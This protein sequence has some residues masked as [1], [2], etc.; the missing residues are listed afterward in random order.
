MSVRDLKDIGIDTPEYGLYA[1]DDQGAGIHTPDIDNMTPGDFDT[2]IDAEV[3]LPI[4]GGQRQHKVTARA[5]D[6][7]EIVWKSQ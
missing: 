4:Y 3:D 7:W 1:D 2:Y 6:C 5:W